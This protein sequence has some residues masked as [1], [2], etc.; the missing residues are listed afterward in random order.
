VIWRLKTFN[1]FELLNRPMAESPNGKDLVIR[2]SG[3]A[4][5]RSGRCLGPGKEPAALETR[6]RG[7]EIKNS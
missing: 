7:N 4:R 5:F 2:K 1:V 6:P 3:V